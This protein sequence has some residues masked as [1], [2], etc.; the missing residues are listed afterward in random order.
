MAGGVS[1]CV[2]GAAGR[3]LAPHAARRT[4]LGICV[5][6]FQI[7]SKAE[8]A[9]GPAFT[10]PLNFL[11]YCHQLGAAGVQIG[12]GIKDETY[13]SKLRQRAEAYDMF[14]E[15]IVGLP[16]DSK[17]VKRFEANVLTAEQAGAHVIR[18][19]MMS[20]RRY[21]RFES[22]EQFRKAAE[23]GLKSLQLAEPVAARHR[24]RLAIENHK[25]H[26]ID[27]RLE[28]IKRLSSE[29]VGICVDTGNSIALL[30]DPMEVTEAY[31][32]WA[33]SA[34]LKDMAVQEYDE[35][36]LL[37]EV[38]L[39]EGFLDLP[40][41][42]QILG[43]AHPELKFSLEM[44]TRDPLRVP[45]LTEKYWATFSDVPG[46]DLARTLTMVRSKA[47]RK[48]L[49]QVSGLSLER[50]LKVEEIN[51]KKCLAFAHEQLSL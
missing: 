38:P 2:F 34:H 42:V 43:Q 24:I 4:G 46:K 21:E 14:I 9:G 33:F 23:Q 25:D 31:A 35:G 41:I 27:E 49:P 6:S 40:K 26:R 1:A 28:V 17:D 12:L 47:F 44:I 13:T 22:A 51:V 20:G 29:Y 32:P 16:R 50:Q 15:G 37:S 3:P 5:H 11:E 45:C 8:Q 10:D 48:A 30:E 39:G 7:R 36:F 19:V 18:T